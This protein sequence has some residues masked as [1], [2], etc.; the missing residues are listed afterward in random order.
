MVGTLL[1]KI[2][3]EQIISQFHFNGMPDEIQE[4]RELMQLVSAA[5]YGRKL[6]LELQQIGGE[7]PQISFVPGMSERSGVFYRKENRIE[8]VRIASNIPGMN[9]KLKAR[10][11]IQ[12]AGTLAHELQ[13]RVDVMKNT[14]LFQNV[15]NR[16]E[17]IVAQVFDE[18][19]AFMRG[20]QVD[21]ELR[22]QNDLL[23]EL[24]IYHHPRDEEGKMRVAKGPKDPMYIR[25]GGKVVREDIR[26]PSPRRRKVALMS[27]LSGKTQR[28]NDYLRKVWRVKNFNPDASHEVFRQNIESYLSY[29]EIPM[30]FDEVMAAVKTCRR[31]RRK[32]R[33]MQSLARLIHGRRQGR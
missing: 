23:N 20:E 2:S 18:M 8:L 21:A 32:S 5:P 22:A 30:T 25:Y 26:L 31:P 3:C 17:L 7:M 15:G 27:A 29:L 13:H 24:Y 14:Q 12:M 28:I 4:L 9:P 33:L 16:E 11:K 10:I 19:S 1:E 6:L